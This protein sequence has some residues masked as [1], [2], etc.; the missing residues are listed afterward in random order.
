MKQIRKL[1]SFRENF[2]HDSRTFRKTIAFVLLLTEMISQVNSDQNT[3]KLNAKTFQNMQHSKFRCIFSKHFR[4]FPKASER[5]RMRPDASKCIQTYP[6]RSK[7]VEAGLNTSENFEKLAKTSNN[8]AK[9]SKMFAKLAKSF[10]SLEP[11][12]MT[13]R[14]PSFALRVPG[15]APR[16][17]RNSFP[18]GGGRTPPGKPLRGYGYEMFE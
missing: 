10:P 18:R 11:E 2:E 6:N 4:K 3:K 13:P 17:V 8:F 5:I 15:S 7:Q 12:M 1:R 14:R 16:Y 9:S